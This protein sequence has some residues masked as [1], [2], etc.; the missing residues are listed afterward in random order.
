MPFLRYFFFAFFM[1][2][3]LVVGWAGFRGSKTT[4]PPIIVFPDMDEQPK[5]KYQTGSEFFADGRGA[6]RPVVGTVPMGLD[7]PAATGTETDKN[8]NLAFSVGSDY[9]HTG[10]FGDF[11]GDGMPEQVAV[12]EALI[13]RGG[14]RYGIYCTPCHGHSGDGQGITAKYGIPTAAGNFHL[15]P[16][17]DP[18]DPTYRT[19]GNI[20]STI[21]YGKGQMGPYGAMIPVQDRWAI[22]AYVRTLQFAKLSTAPLTPTAPAAAPPAAPGQPPPPG[23]QPAA[24]APPSA[25]PG[26]PP[27]PAAQ[28]GS[29][30]P[31]PQ[32][33]QAQRPVSPQP[34]G[35]TVTPP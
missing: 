34:P 28:P 9:Y 23:A 17:A 14:E 3:L 22:I 33:P 19:D 26:S 15:P 7:M 10:R 13:R 5:V 16:L 30:A 18:K 27:P 11:W 2:C 25:A 1:I 32:S 24:P 29:T 21:T 20:F 35:Q 6:R 31:A 8:A 4:S 12:D